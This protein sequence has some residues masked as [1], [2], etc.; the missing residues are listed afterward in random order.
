M[1]NL[2]PGD[3]RTMS[4]KVL[5]TFISIFSKYSDRLFTEKINEKTQDFLFKKVVIITEVAALHET[6][7]NNKYTKIQ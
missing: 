6:T 1:P 7:N 5:C 3:K 2:F 4:L